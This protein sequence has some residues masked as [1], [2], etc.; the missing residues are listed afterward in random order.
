[1]NQRCL[2]RIPTEKVCKRDSLLFLVTS[3]L[4]PGWIMKVEV[5]DKSEYDKLMSPEEYAQFLSDSA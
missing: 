3:F 2:T 5:S 1:M 4:S